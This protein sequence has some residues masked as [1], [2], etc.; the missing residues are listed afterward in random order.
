[1]N[2][3]SFFKTVRGKSHVSRDAGYPYEDGKY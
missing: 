2:N 1:M 3:I